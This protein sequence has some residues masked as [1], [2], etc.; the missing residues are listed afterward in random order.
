MGIIGLARPG[1]DSIAEKAHEAMS[2]DLNAGTR[3]SMEMVNRRRLLLE[4]L[5]KECE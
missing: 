5:S 3:I 1:L 4:V 2:T